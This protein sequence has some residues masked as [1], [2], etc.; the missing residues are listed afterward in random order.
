M[1]NAVS[2]VFTGLCALVAGA[3]D[4]PAQVL[5]A[6][7]KHVGSIGGVT[8]P[9]HAPT[10]VVSLSAVANAETSGPTRVVTAWPGRGSAAASS[11]GLSFGVPEQVG[12]W[13]LWGMEVRIRTQGGEGAGARVFHPRAGESTWPAPPRDTGDPAAWRDIRYVPDMHALTGDGRIDPALMA[14][15]TALPDR[16]AAR[17]IIDRGTLQAGIPSQKLFRDRVFA[18]SGADGEEKARQALTDAVV[19]TL[20]NGPGTVVVE[21]AS[22]DGASVKR[23]VLAPG[24]APHQLFISNLPSESGH[25]ALGEDEMAALHFGAYY[26]LLMEPAGDRPLPR[27]WP[28]PSR[29]RAVGLAGTTLCPPALFRRP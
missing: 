22:V 16:V 5:L 15:D 7:A 8:L 1:S 2:I 19:W 4:R 11:P 6:D 14:T 28:G 21:I 27:P 9:E 3:D 25:H 10:L 18:F 20:D 23:L 26:E 12:L 24:A 13:D 17:V 29:R